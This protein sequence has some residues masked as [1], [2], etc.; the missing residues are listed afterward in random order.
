ME[1]LLK[2][3][4]QQT[5]TPAA[6]FSTPDELPPLHISLNLPKAWPSHI[7]PIQ[8]KSVAPQKEAAKPERPQE[9]SVSKEKLS[10]D[11]LSKW[12][13]FERIMGCDLGSTTTRSQVVSI[14]RSFA[15]KNHPDMILTADSQRFALGVKTKNE[16]L[17]VINAHLKKS[18]NND[19]RP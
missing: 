12:G 15:K 18:I 19:A 2:K 1:T 10:E 13:L 16:L 7:Y 17:V 6:T 9:P 14:F 4:A 11:E 8:H 5:S 3:E